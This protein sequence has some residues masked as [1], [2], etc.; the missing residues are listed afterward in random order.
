MEWLRSRV[1][2]GSEKKNHAISAGIATASS[3]RRISRQ[4]RCVRLVSISDAWKVIPAYNPE[5]KDSASGEAP[6]AVTLLLIPRFD[7]RQPDAPL[8]DAPFWMPSAT[9]LNRGGS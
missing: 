2:C 8:P 1:R 9:T 5:L 6:G 7:P 4:L 3:P